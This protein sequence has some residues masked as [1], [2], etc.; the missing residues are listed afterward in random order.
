MNVCTQV[1]EQ[2]GLTSLRNAEIHLTVG[3]RRPPDRLGTPRR[4]LYGK[5]TSARALSL[6]PVHLGLLHPQSRRLA[7]LVAA[8]STLANGT[9][10]DSLS[11]FRKRAG[12]QHFY[13]EGDLKRGAERPG[14]YATSPCPTSC[15]RSCTPDRMKAAMIC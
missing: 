6:R 11:S 8:M 12:F 4:A 1:Q 7:E 15:K 2:R 10:Q 13:S 3:G 5:E 14:V 9:P